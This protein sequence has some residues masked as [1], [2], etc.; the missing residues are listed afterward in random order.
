MDAPR[1]P[2]TFHLPFEIIEGIV[3]FTDIPEAQNCALTCKALLSQS[4]A[5]IF[6]HVRIVPI[7]GTSSNLRQLLV[8]SPHLEKFIQHVALLD[9]HTVEQGIIPIIVD[10]MERLRH[11][12]TISLVNRR[13]L[14]C[15]WAGVPI[16]L[17]DVLFRCFQL[18]TLHAVDAQIFSKARSFI[19]RCPKLQHLEMYEPY[20][21]ENWVQS[22][23]IVVPVVLKSFR[24][25]LFGPQSQIGIDTILGTSGEPIVNF[26]HLEKL[27][28]DSRST[29]RAPHLLFQSGEWISQIAHFAADSLVE[30]VWDVGSPDIQSEQ[31]HVTLDM[32]PC[33]T[34]L[35]VRCRSRLGLDAS[36]A[37]A[38]RLMLSRNLS[39]TLL[40]ASFTFDW[41]SDPRSACA[42][43]KTVKGAQRIVLYFQRTSLPDLSESSQV[44][45]EE[46]LDFLRETAGARH[47]LSLT[48][49]SLMDL[50]EGDAQLRYLRTDRPFV[51]GKLHQ[52]LV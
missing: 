3:Y 13:V 51:R 15:S 33:L 32:F 37:W 2:N 21:T 41:N 17:Q 36:C 40:I 44:S 18:E 47:D 48:V 16:S 14:G 8:D 22:S 19:E 28:L 23:P 31:L 1:P 27:V 6:S 52:I 7:G 5:N 45:E 34:T 25:I 43:I 39:S 35:R 29:P 26:S 49:M 20:Q 46:T 50:K 30:L 38:T 10:I 11:L 24:V 42:F 4:R 9:L 12:R